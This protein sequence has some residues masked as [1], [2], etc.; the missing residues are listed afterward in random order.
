MLKYAE[1]FNHHTGEFEPTLLVDYQMKDDPFIEKFLVTHNN[2]MSNLSNIMNNATNPHDIL[3]WRALTCEWMR[4][5]RNHPRMSFASVTNAIAIF[6]IILSKST[7]HKEKIQLT[8]II[9]MLISSKIHDDDSLLIDDILQDMCEYYKLD[10]IKQ[11]EYEIVRLLDWKIDQITPSAYIANCKLPHDVS[12]I[13]LHIA[14][15]TTVTTISM[16]LSPANIAIMSIYHAIR[17]L[18]DEPSRNSTRT[19]ITIS[20]LKI[21]F[22]QQYYCDMISERTELIEWFRMWYER[23][24]I[25]V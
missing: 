19:V 1:I 25:W 22:I 16:R 6:D 20:S 23:P 5:F 12:E 13:A 14:E 21:P 4:D 17:L 18:G 7:V 15:L 3:K 8:A 2:W 9:A 10:E 24:S 11:K